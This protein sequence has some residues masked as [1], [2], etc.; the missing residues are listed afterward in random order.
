MRR[1]RGLTAAAAVLFVA[2]VL[3]VA[4]GCGGDAPEMIGSPTPSVSGS[5]TETTGDAMDLRSLPAMTTP[6]PVTALYQ[7][8]DI[9]GGLQ[10]FI[11]TAA[12]DLAEGL[13]VSASDVTTHAAVLVIWPDPS[14]GCPAKGMRYAQ[15]P[16]DGSIIE[17]G[18]AGRVYRYHTG[19]ARGPFQCAA[20]L[21]TAPTRMG[22][23]PSAEG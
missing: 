9:D 15:V 7:S 12:A 21:T 16:T 10:P 22:T 6:I 3:L 8:G 20:P 4:A 5:P 2:A 11:D 19:G 1:C 18:H 17:L 13:G 14:L 23:A